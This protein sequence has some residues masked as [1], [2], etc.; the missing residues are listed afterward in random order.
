MAKK[1][2]ISNNC[3]SVNVKINNLE[4]I[5]IIVLKLCRVFC[6]KNGD[7]NEC[8]VMQKLLKF[9]IQSHERMFLNRKFP[10]HRLFIIVFDHMFKRVFFAIIDHVKLQ[11]L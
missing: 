10:Y 11:L 7:L 6:T 3:F 1:I 5:N 2:R 4:K 8:L 9:I